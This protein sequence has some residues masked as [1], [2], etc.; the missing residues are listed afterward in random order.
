MSAALPAVATAINPLSQ[1]PQVHLHVAVFLAGGQVLG[2]ETF[3]LVAF[4][5][6]ESISECFEYTLELH[7]NSSPMPAT[8]VFFD[9]ILGQPVTFAVHYPAPD[10]QGAQ[11][12]RA[13]ANAWFRQALAGEDH[14]SQLVFFN[15][16]VASF[17]MERP[18]VYRLTVRPALWCLTLTNRY[19]VYAGMSVRDVIVA[20]LDR[21]R[22]AYSVDALVGSDNLAVTR[23]QD[24]LQ[25]GES[26]HEF[27]KRVLAKAH[28]YFFFTSQ[29]RSHR[30]VFANRPAYPQALA[31]G[32]ALHY[33]STDAS[34]LG[35]AQ[36]DVVTDYRYQQTLATSSVNTVFARE[37]AAWEVDGLPTVHTFRAQT[38][39]DPGP[40]PFHQY[41][42][43]E[44]GCSD[45]EADQYANETQ[46]ALATASREFSGASNCARLRCGHQFRL[47]QY[48]R[49]RQQPQP[50]DIALEGLQLVVTSVEHQASLDGSYGNTIRAVPAAGLATPCSLQETQQGAILGVVVAGHAGAAPAEW[51]HFDNGAFDPEVSRLS[52][53]DATHPSVQA[54]GVYVRLSSD[55]EGSAAVWVKLAP[56]MQ[57]APE[58]GAMVLVARA[59]DQSELPEIQST[60]QAN[61]NKVL[62]PSGWS[63]STNIGNNWSA[64]YGDALSVR[65]GKGTTADLAG[66]VSKVNDP[67]TSGQYRECSFAQGATWNYATSETGA[68]GVLSR[69]E[70]YGSAY[71]THHGAESKSSTVFGSTDN[72]STVS[73]VAN[74]KSMVGVNASMSLVGQQNEMS[75]IGE[76]NRLTV[77]G[78]S[79]DVTMRGLS[80][81]VDMMGAG[82][83]IQLALLQKTIQTKGP[84][85]TLSEIQI[86]V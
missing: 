61:G 72:D 35:R 33:C 42:V 58:I 26:D 23:V 63:A 41:L 73:G 28:V 9:A 44:Y 78:G 48:P 3:R 12:T 77:M 38:R 11:A 18:G 69:S 37:E 74:S 57:T 27:L 16:I 10:A 13:E 43:Y 21:H 15:G 30:I 34:E 81:S 71:S 64:S 76:S 50:V 8:A 52:D 40:L 17:A 75:V 49:E 54:Q 80:T 62:K 85:I 6:Q 31:A 55:P 2:D 45:A 5:G 53:S 32:Q 59:Q 51:R 39:G 47:T 66:A 20:V 25:A 29:P 24:W 82:L 14:A 56:H 79:V 60:V 67:Y 7:G 86:F 83:S 1:A 46:D 70:S 4:Q 36:V 68:A 65:F 22:I 19:Q 84:T